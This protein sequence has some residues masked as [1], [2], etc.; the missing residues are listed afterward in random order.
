MNVCTEK[1]RKDI[2]ELLGIMSNSHKLSDLERAKR[3]LRWSRNIVLISGS[4]ILEGTTLPEYFTIDGIKKRAQKTNYYE[5]GSH[6]LSDSLQPT[7]SHKFISNL[8]KQGKLL[9]NYTENVDAPERK[10]GISNVYYCN[11]SF[12]SAVCTDCHRVFSQELMKQHIL[13]GRLLRC[14]CPSKGLVNPGLVFS[15]STHKC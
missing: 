13:S 5:L 9:R 8:E 4:E 15:S 3:L 1:L 14:S 10:A 11:G 7:F 12:A 2:L 6:L